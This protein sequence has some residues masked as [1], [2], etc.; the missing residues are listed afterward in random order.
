MQIT[1]QN[2]KQMEKETFVEELTDK[3]EDVNNESG[4]TDIKQNELY[5]LVN[6]FAQIEKNSKKEF[7]N[8]CTI[9]FEE[10]GTS[11][12]NFINITN[13]NSLYHSEEF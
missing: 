10:I 5:Y 4:C 6:S 8:K 9:Y 13:I 2:I 12:I 1:P 7:N 3:L 11:I